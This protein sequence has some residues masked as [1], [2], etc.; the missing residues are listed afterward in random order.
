MYWA[1]KKYNPFYYKILSLEAALALELICL[2]YGWK[3]LNPWNP[4]HTRERLQESFSV[5]DL[6]QIWKLHSLEHQCPLLLPPRWGRG[7][8][9][10]SGTR[11]DFSMPA[12]PQQ[13]ALWPECQCILEVL[14][15][16]CRS[17]NRGSAQT[18]EKL[19]K[20]AAE[21][22]LWFFRQHRVGSFLGTS[23]V[24]KLSS[25]AAPSSSWGPPNAYTTQGGRR[26]VPFPSARVEQPHSGLHI[27]SFGF[28]RALNGTRS[29]SWIT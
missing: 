28:S 9:F 10:L 4:V 15:S 27:F 29:H 1:H 2:E 13:A 7:H 16:L 26:P 24:E 25:P 6:S 14:P 22:E 20:S 19:R 18:S 11:K 23:Q 21:K 8:T 17:D 5:V 12:L 3:I